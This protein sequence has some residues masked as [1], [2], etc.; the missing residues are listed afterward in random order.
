M[1]NTIG[2][3]QHK[4]I[5]ESKDNEQAA[6]RR[7]C[8]DFES[9]LISLMIKGMRETVPQS[10]SMLY[11]GFGEDIYRSMMDEEIARNISRCPGMGLA[12][13]IYRQLSGA[14]KV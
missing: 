4:T 2:K 12:E 9:V 14:K 10:D 7:A 11:G 8:Q 5:S 13:I 3:I 6:L 1:S